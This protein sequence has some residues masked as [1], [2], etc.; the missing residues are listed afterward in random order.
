MAIPAAYIKKDIDFNTRFRGLL[1]VMKLI[2]VSQYYQLQG[3]FR[4][5]EKISENVSQFFRSFDMT[6]IHHP[7]VTPGD[8]PPAVLAV[9]S[10]NG[11]LGGLNMQVMTRA[12]DLVNQTGGRLLVVGEKGQFYAQSSGLGYTHFPGIVDDQRYAQSNQVCMYVVERVLNGTFGG[13]KVVYPRSP[14]IVIQTIHTATLLPIGEMKF[15]DAAK[16]TE[17]PQTSTRSID[18][19]DVILESRPQDIV[20]YL[21]L[22]A[23]RE[24][25]FQIF[26]MARIAEQAARFTHLEESCN[27]ILEMNKKLLLQYF[28]RRHE[29][30][31]QNMRELFSARSLFARQAD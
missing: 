31:D 4:T 20:E 15:G 25:L 23:M 5:F 12:L 22:V 9:T 11:L 1:E 17:K 28:K 21:A 3:K 14:S 18:S 6:A 19:E 10:D 30:I 2:A 8:K 24:Q 26:G 7:F 16:E 27:K 13:L 29:T